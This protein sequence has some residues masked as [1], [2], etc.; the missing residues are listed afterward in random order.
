MKA[1]GILGKAVLG[2]SVFGCMLVFILIISGIFLRPSTASAD[3]EN[4]F[5]D[6]QLLNTLS[7]NISSTEDIFIFFDGV[8]GEVQESGYEGWCKVVTFKQGQIMI[9][10]GGS[11]RSTSD[12]VF[13]DITILKPLDKASP[14]LAE[15]VCTGRIIRTVKIDVRK[16][17]NSTNQTT[18]YKYELGNAMVTSYSVSGSSQADELPVENITLSFEQI[19]ATYTEFDDTGKAKGNIEYTWTID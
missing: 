16:I 11:G 18:F 4:S 6:Q 3:Y 13:D 5:S 12:V 7:S 9:K 1:K 19:K 15:A 10:D 8:S 2:I 14:K 17:L